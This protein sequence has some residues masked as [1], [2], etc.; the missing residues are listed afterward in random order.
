M[1]LPKPATITL[2]LVFFC[3][4]NSNANAQLWRYLNDSPEKEKAAELAIEREASSVKAASMVA[5]SDTL[6]YKIIT[7]DIQTLDGLNDKISMYYIPFSGQ[8][9]IKSTNDSLNIVDYTSTD[10][11]HFINKNFLELLYSPRGG[12]D[13]GY[14][15]TMILYVMNGKIGIAMQIETD[16]QF[17]FAKGWGEY[18][19]TVK[20]TGENRDSYK[21]HVKTNDRLY[22]KAKHVRSLNL[23][24][25]FVLNYDKKRNIFYNNFR[26]INGRS[27]IWDYSTDKL[28]IKYFK[29]KYPV[30]KLD[31][32]N[33]CYTKGIWYAVGKNNFN[34]KSTLIADCIR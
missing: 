12:S 23:N 2:L 16:H 29:G 18:Y 5:Y 4:F 34:G 1:T 24:N 26:M 13:D 19:A 20:L 22:S 21:L 3:L 15:N 32:H 25:R 9:T 8:L 17:D 6:R 10:S 31:D 14:Q 33:Y 30:I 28:H 7:Y 27:C 11:V